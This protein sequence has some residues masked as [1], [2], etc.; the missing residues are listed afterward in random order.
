MQAV[1]WESAFIKRPEARG[2]ET[3]RHAGVPRKHGAK[4]LCAVAVALVCFA[5][6][7]AKAQ[8][9][10]TPAKATATEYAGVIERNVPAK[11]R[12]G[13][14]LRADIYRPKA[15]GKFPVLLT[16]TPYDKTGTL[17]FGMRGAARGYVVVAQDVRGRYQSEGEFY[18]FQNELNDGY[19][20]VE[21]AAALPYSNGKVGMTGGSYVG[22][23]QMLASIAHPPHLAGIMPPV[24][25]S[26]YH[27]NWTYHGGALEQWFDQNWTTQL[28][29]N[30]M[31]K[32]IEKDTNA[33]VG[34]T[35]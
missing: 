9:S 13:V 2:G 20:T 7:G 25:S 11:M 18:T 35:T 34:T 24:T 30:T 4:A 26:N 8:L 29:T 15:A 1:R 6:P 19:D 22:A 5:V 12:D 10:G 27:A 32:L 28:A 3:Q 31:W 14:T 16:R 23:T 21:W 17:E 33:L